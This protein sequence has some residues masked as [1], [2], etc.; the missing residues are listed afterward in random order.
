MTEQAGVE[1]DSSALLM[2]ASDGWDCWSE[3]K[4]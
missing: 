4:R 1:C 3:A 2:L